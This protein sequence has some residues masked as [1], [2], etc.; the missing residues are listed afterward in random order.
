[1]GHHQISKYLISINDYQ[2]FQMFN[3]FKVVLNSLNF[4]QGIGR[5][6]THISRR[7]FFLTSRYVINEIKIHYLA[8]TKMVLRNLLFGCFFPILSVF[9]FSKSNCFAYHRAVIAP[10]YCHITPGVVRVNFCIPELSGSFR[11]RQDSFWLP[12][13]KCRDRSTGEKQRVMVE[14]QPKIK[15]LKVMFYYRK[16]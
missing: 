13:F 8:Q 7:D 9:S 15:S 1:M 12:K 10:P 14:K 5:L 2:Y 3:K 6:P 4:A 16:Q 11:S